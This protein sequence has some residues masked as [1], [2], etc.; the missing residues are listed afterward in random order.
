MRVRAPVLQ[1]IVERGFGFAGDPARPHSGVFVHVSD[2]EGA[3]LDP[4]EVGDVLEFELVFSSRGPRAV[5]AKIVK[6]AD[7]RARR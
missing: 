4:P 7:A 2:L 5:R 1:W 3:A 6:R